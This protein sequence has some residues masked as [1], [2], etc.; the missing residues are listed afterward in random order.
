ML[1]AGRSG[2][3]IIAMT[4]KLLSQ[5]TEKTQIIVRESQSVGSLRQN[6]PAQPLIFL[7]VMRTI[8]VQE[9]PPT[10]FFQATDRL[11]WNIMHP[12]SYILDLEPSLFPLFEHLNDDFCNP[13]VQTDVDVRC[14]VRKTESASSQTAS[15]PFFWSTWETYIQEVGD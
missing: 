5:V 11:I 14:I 13:F 2:W 3:N 9:R 15:I 4:V 8:H 1:P 6:I 12:T 7:L 10:L